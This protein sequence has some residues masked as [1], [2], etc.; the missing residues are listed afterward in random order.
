MG[1]S[2]FRESEGTAE[3]RHDLAVVNT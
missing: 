3:P 1:I 2:N